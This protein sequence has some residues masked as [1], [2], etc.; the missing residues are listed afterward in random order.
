MPKVFTRSPRCWLS[1]TRPSNSKHS[2][3]YLRLLVLR[4]TSLLEETKLS[5]LSIKGLKKSKPTET[6]SSTSWSSWIT[7]CP[8]RMVLRQRLKS[9]ALLK[10]S[11]LTRLSTRIGPICAV[12]VPTL[13]NHSFSEP[14]VSEFKIT[15]L[16]RRRSLPLTIS[17]T[18]WSSS[19]LIK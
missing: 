1:T 17:S 8:T 9:L 12:W 11:G 7:A 6:T 14:K 19:E 4:Q 18:N 13:T 15:C 16:S 2:N 10:N 3:T 5:N